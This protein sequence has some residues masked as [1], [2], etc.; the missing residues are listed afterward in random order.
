[1]MACETWRSLWFERIGE[2]RRQRFEPGIDDGPH[3]ILRLP[4]RHYHDYHYKYV[5]WISQRGRG[6]SGSNTS[7]IAAI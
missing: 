1:M 2:S 4:F 6:Q 7:A 3:K 5:P